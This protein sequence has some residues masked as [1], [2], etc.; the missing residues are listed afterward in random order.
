MLHRNDTGSA[1]LFPTLGIQVEPGEVVDLPDELGHVRQLT[2]VD[3]DGNEIPEPEVE[4]GPDGETLG[5]ADPAHGDLDTSVP[6]VDVEASGKT[7][8]TRKTTTTA[9]EG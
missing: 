5:L 3:A 2:V 9:Q 8:R 1:H 6:V 7:A 4:T